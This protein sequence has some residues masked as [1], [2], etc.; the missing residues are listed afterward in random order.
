MGPLLALWNVRD[1]GFIGR[2]M[3]SVSGEKKCHSSF[4]SITYINSSLFMLM[5]NRKVPRCV[6]ASFSLMGFMAHSD[7]F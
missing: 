7:I 2:L 4:H 1:G 6:L 5:A 3:S